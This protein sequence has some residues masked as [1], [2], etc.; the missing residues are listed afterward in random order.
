MHSHVV[1]NHEIR[2]THIEEV[3]F[4]CLPALVP[5][6]P[7]RT[8]L[9]PA[10]QVVSAHLLPSHA[11]LHLSRSFPRVILTGTVFITLAQLFVQLLLDFC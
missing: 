5:P 8:L 11:S 2:Q 6:P 9:P 3:L 7:L 1:I 10:I 4:R